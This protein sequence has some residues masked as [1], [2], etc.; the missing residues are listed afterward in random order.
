MSCTKTLF[1]VPF[2]LEVVVGCITAFSAEKTPRHTLRPRTAC[3][4]RNCEPDG[5]LSSG[6]HVCCKEGEVPIK[7]SDPVKQNGRD[8]SLKEWTVRVPTKSG[9]DTCRNC[10]GVGKVPTNFVR[11]KKGRFPS[12]AGEVMGN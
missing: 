9:R 2:F 6:L 4:R 5:N 11:G 1:V 7:Q 3:K 12:I 8:A 10:Y